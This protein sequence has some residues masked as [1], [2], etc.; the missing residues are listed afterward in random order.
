MERQLLSIRRLLEDS[1]SSEGTASPLSADDGDI[2]PPR[3]SHYLVAASISWP[4]LKIYI[5]PAQSPLTEPRHQGKSE[6]IRFSFCFLF[7][8]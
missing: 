6:A 8:I 3:K 1:D 4:T 2:V 7:N 5:A